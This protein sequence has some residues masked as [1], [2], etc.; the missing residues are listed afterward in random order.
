MG[1][2]YFVVLDNAPSMTEINNARTYLTSTQGYNQFFNTTNLPQL[3][4]A[5]DE[6]FILS[7]L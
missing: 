2:S 7:K 5:S 6:T 3:T 4:D 1:Y